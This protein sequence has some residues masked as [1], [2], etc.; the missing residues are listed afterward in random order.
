M[1]YPEG[2]VLEAQPC[3]NGCPPGDRL[4]LE[5]T[6]LLHAVPGRF[7]V[8]RCATCGLMR[9]DPRPNAATI[10]I[11]YPQDYGPHHTAVQAA[12]PA[13][14]KKQKWYY[15][16][17]ERIRR[18]FRREARTLPPIK[19][20]HLLEIGCASG[21]F[22]AQVRDKGWTAEGIE[23]SAEAAE[24]ARAMGFHVQV[25]TVETAAPPQ[26]KADVLAAW[27]VIEHLHDPVQSL[28]RLRDWVEP[29]GY[30]IASVPDAGALTAR[31]FG[32]HWYAL[33]VPRHLYHFS[34]ATMRTTLANAGW[35][36]VK[37]GRQPNFN[38]LLRSLD[39][40]FGAKGWTRAQHVV[41]RLRTAPEHARFRARLAWF[42]S[43]VR[44]SG[45]LEIWAR[46]IQRTP[47]A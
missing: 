36:L 6:D 43:F 17:R 35:E 37:V 1:T 34:T 10:G 42:L 3:P 28:R 11:Y 40:W 18:V 12:A 29:G 16:P 13:K 44:E 33:D 38:I 24:R 25:A 30:L 2:L 21:A 23:F 19:P 39:N 27:M 20:G 26:R 9:T 31:V 41:A 22:L 4:V 7:K 5:G 32:R 46:P 14:K 45:S 15:G 47:A 8:V